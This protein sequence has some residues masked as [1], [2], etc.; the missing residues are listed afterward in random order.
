MEERAH[1]VGGVLTIA[2]N[3]SEGTMIKVSL[4]CV[5]THAALAQPSFVTG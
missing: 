4:P 2:S 5:A 3:V 1:L